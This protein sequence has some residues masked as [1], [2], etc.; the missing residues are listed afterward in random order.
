MARKFGNLETQKLYDKTHGSSSKSGG[1]SF[2]KPGGNS[3]GKP[4]QD[5]ENAFED[6]EQQDG[7]SEDPEQVVAEHGKANELK[8]TH[9]DEQGTHHVHSKHQDGH[10]THSQHSSAQEAHTHA[11][12]LAG[13]E[14]GQTEAEAAPIGGGSEG[15]IPTMG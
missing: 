4:G 5:E 1:S 6:H 15:G 12:S 2:G 14:P 7:Q 3:F 9:D 13:V 10:T 8:I 11:A